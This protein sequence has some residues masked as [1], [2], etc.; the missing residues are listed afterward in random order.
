MKTLKFVDDVEVILAYPI[1]LKERLQLPIDVDDMLF[2]NFSGVTDS[3]LKNAQDFVEDAWKNDK[4]FY[5]FLIQQPKWKEALKQHF[6][7]EYSENKLLILT[8]KALLKR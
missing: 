7:E 4:G 6:K 1:M 2:F 3:D 5:Q 8:E